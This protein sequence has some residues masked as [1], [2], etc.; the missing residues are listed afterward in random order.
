[1]E[2]RNEKKAAAAATTAE[3]AMNSIK[4]KKCAVLYE[5]EQ[6]MCVRPHNA[7]DWDET[8]TSQI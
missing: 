8:N 5:Q 3:V 7:A 2:R 1:M 4:I 6:E